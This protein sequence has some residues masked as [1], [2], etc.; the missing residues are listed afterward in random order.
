[1][2][3]SYKKGEPF[4]SIDD[5]GFEKM[6]QIFFLRNVSFNLIFF[7]YLCLS[8]LL[9]FVLLVRTILFEEFQKK[10]KTKKKNIATDVQLGA[11][12]EIDHNFLNLISTVIQRTNPFHK[13]EVSG[14][15]I[16]NIA[17]IREHPWS[18]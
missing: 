14:W 10:K 5:P 15:D 8:F 11:T 16:N 6:F 17:F 12:T 1:M 4:S 18:T 9:F 13:Q 2:A 7:V 3:G